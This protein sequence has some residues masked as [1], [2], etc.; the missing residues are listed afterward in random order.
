ME[1]LRTP[2]R[3]DEKE[4]GRFLNRTKV[5]WSS[6]NMEDL[7]SNAGPFLELLFSR[8]SR[9]PYEF[10]ESD[11]ADPFTL[12]KMGFWPNPQDPANVDIW[13]KFDDPD[14]NYSTY[15]DFYRTT[16]REERLQHA[17]DGLRTLE[18]GELA[19]EI[20]QQI[21]TLLVNVCENMVGAK[22]FENIPELPDDGAEADFGNPT[23]WRPQPPQEDAEDNND[24][25]EK[26]IRDSRSLQVYKHGSEIDWA[27]L[28]RLADSE[29]VSAR[30]LLL[31]MREDPG[32]FRDTLE[33]NFALQPVEMTTAYEGEQKALRQRAMRDFEFRPSQRD[34]RKLRDSIVCAVYRYECWSHIFRLIVQ[35]EGRWEAYETAR[36]EEGHLHAEFEVNFKT[37]YRLIHTMQYDLEK[38]NRDTDHILSAEP[39]FQQYFSRKPT[40]G[41]GA[42]K[43]QVFELDPRTLATWPEGEDFTSRSLTEMLSRIRAMCTNLNAFPVAMRHMAEELDKCSG[44]TGLALSPFTRQHLQSLIAYGIFEIEFERFTWLKPVFDDIVSPP[45]SEWKRRV[46]TGLGPRIPSVADG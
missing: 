22:D 20:Q 44:Q 26:F 39:R 40:I 28:K 36:R 12:F 23:E 6:Y 43:G 27:F 33:E 25:L 41:S 34:I 3:N 17:S 7:S 4:W 18:Q 10:F 30:T 46:E 32:V 1:E 31:G 16:T 15:G 14:T 11:M 5:L 45:K 35:I 8:A 29:R 13:M 21:Y 2:P 42:E 9:N 19:L 37:L 38:R 24:R